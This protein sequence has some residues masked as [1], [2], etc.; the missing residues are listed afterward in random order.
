VVFT[1]IILLTDFVKRVKWFHYDK[2]K[3]EFIEPNSRFQLKPLPGSYQYELDRCPDGVR[4]VQAY[5]DCK[6]RLR[7]DI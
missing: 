3:L 4:E 7:K 2:E 5:L 1:Y 6:R